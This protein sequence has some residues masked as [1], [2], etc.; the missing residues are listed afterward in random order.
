[1]LFAAALSSCN[2]EA[3]GSE[4]G[5]V[6]GTLRISVAAG[7]SPKSQADAEMSIHCL[8]LLVF[9]TVSGELEQ[10]LDFDAGTTSATISLPPGPKTIWAYANHAV[11]PE[12]TS[13]ASQPITGS[14]TLMDDA[15]G[16]ACFPM[17]GSVSVLLYSGSN[18]SRVLYLDRCASR[19]V[20][21]SIRNNL[22]GSLP[23]TVLGA[24]LADTYLADTPG[25]VLEDGGSWTSKWGRTENL[26]LPTEAS[27]TPYSNN[28]WIDTDLPHTISNGT[29][30]TI[31]LPAS[32]KG[33]RLYCMPNTSADQGAPWTA[34]ATWTPAVTKLVI[35]ARIGSGARFYYPI[36][37]PDIQANESREYNISI[38]GIGT[39]DPETLAGTLTC[40]VSSSSS[41]YDPGSTYT[42]SIE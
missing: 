5:P 8:S 23:L 40:S 31:P 17:R 2:G 41:P 3:P 28:A 24:Y 35:I 7:F 29:A 30:W 39:Q 36:P 15:F 42:D 13:L 16:N 27:F 12:G 26:T 6:Q 18:I 32:V 33:P 10:A 38:F 37:L 14:G 4:T 25:R 11:N 9:N 19:V 22:P 21:S 34:C 1:M 20:V